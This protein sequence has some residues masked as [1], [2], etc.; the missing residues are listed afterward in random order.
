MI[1]WVVRSLDNSFSRKDIGDATSRES[2]SCVAQYQTLSHQ[3]NTMQTE[4]PIRSISDIA[5]ERWAFFRPHRFRSTCGKQQT[6]EG[7]FEPPNRGGFLSCYK[8]PQAKGWKW[9]D[10]RL[11]VRLK[12]PTR[13]DEEAE[14][15]C[16]PL[17][18]LTKT[19]KHGYP[20]FSEEPVE[21]SK[22]EIENI[23]YRMKNSKTTPLTD[24]RDWPMKK[25]TGILKEWLA[26]F[27]T[28]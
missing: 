11:H 6:I 3:D 26:I 12:M 8:S 9:G 5:P 13:C 23:I 20:V 7:I 25:W 17:Y 4:S 21:M 2:T 27:Y 28:D 24:W 22:S 18:G 14:F 16:K 15:A 10:E 1:P 19:N